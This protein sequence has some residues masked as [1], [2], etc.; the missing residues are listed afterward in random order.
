MRRVEIKSY[1]FPDD[2]MN[3]SII[4]KDGPEEEEELRYYM[5][6]EAVMA[7]AWAFLEGGD[8]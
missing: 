5:T 1:P 3:W 7:E 4:F 2:E 8:D 6:K